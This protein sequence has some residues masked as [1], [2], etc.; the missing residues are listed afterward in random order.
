[1]RV[2][3]VVG[4][5]TTSESL[6]LYVF[7]LLHL[8]T[9][10]GH[11]QRLKSCVD[12]T[13]VWRRAGPT[14]SPG[15][16]T[17]YNH[18]C[19]SYQQQILLMLACHCSGYQPVASAEKAV[20]KY[21]RQSIRSSHPRHQARRPES[22]R[23]S[24]RHWKL[25][26]VGIDGPG[27]GVS[28]RQ[29]VDRYRSRKSSKSDKSLGHRRIRTSERSFQNPHIRSNF[30]LEERS[31]CYGKPNTYRSWWEH[32]HF[33]QTQSLHS[34]HSSRHTGRCQSHR[35]RHKSRKRC[36]FRHRHNRS[37]ER[38]QCRGSCRI[39]SF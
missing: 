24:R 28:R 27:C 8:A 13:L 26:W 33:Q 37:S 1:M 18:R 25:G 39:V 10:F 23:I 30:S 14:K 12:E 36:R 15:V 11:S 19:L 34:A 3:S 7:F 22:L 9:N 16:C 31:L 20:L 35:T 5:V 32:S 2:R 38:G 6:M 4:S 21:G 29:G 17:K